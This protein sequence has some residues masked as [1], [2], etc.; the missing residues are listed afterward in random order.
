M[1]SARG[2]G[3]V[4]RRWHPVHRWTR[5][6]R[7][8]PCPVTRGQ[9]AGGTCRSSVRRGQGAG[10]APTLPGHPW[11][12]CGRRRA[13]DGLPAAD[14][15]GEAPAAPGPRRHE[16]R[17]ADSTPSTREPG[18]GRSRPRDVHRGTARPDE[19]A[20]P[21]LTADWGVSATDDTLSTRRLTDRGFSAACPCGRH[22]DDG[23][24]R[25]TPPQAPL[26]GC[27]TG[28]TLSSA[29]SASSALTWTGALNSST[30]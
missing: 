9:G 26:H 28:A 7:F 24:R 3:V 30:A 13:T 16:A 18:A 21:G 23:F 27:A 8:R 1:R 4:G 22:G 15:G 19:A 10:G 25:S 5:C 17:E 2:R 29:S 6:G 11:T 12:R 20:P 14:E